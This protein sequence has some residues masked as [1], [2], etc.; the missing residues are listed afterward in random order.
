M[1]WAHCCLPWIQ[2]LLISLL[3]LYLKPRPYKTWEYCYRS[4]KRHSSETLSEEEERSS[5]D[6]HARMAQRRGRR[7]PGVVRRK[8]GRRRGEEVERGHIFPKLGRTGSPI[9]T[10]CTAGRCKKI[11]KS[12]STNF[13]Q[14]HS[15][16][17][18]FHHQPWFWWICPAAQQ[19]ESATHRA[20]QVRRSPWLLLAILRVWYQF[21]SKLF[22]HCLDKATPHIFK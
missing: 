12:I 3:Y 18:F 10:E 14:F 5:G 2:I 15:L 13:M 8:E 7:C 16:S 11:R 22:M 9:M 20:S 6:E 4:R 17:N 21:Q 19:A 1:W